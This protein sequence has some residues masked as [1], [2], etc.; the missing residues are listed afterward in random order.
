MARKDG[1]LNEDARE[2]WIIKKYLWARVD[3]RGERDEVLR[4]TARFLV[5]ATGS[6]YLPFFATGKTRGWSGLDI[7][8]WP[9]LCLCPGHQGTPAPLV[10]LLRCGLVS[11]P[12]A[13][14]WIWL[15]LL[16]CCPHPQ[17]PGMVLKICACLGQT[18]VCGCF[19]LKPPTYS[20][21]QHI[22]SYV[23]LWFFFLRT[24][25]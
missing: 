7:K 24:P 4:M 23:K 9:S 11:S 5:R 13:W 18:T 20:E 14:L 3:R 25:T 2:E 12:P 19:V 6:L 8:W 22:N 21:S 15:L 17:V 16:P 10:C 1:D